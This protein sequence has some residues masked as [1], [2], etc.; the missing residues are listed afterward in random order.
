[1]LRVYHVLAVL[2]FVVFGINA[3]TAYDQ[4]LDSYALRAQFQYQMRQ[5]NVMD[6]PLEDFFARA[7][8]V[9]K[10][11]VHSFS[12]CSN[13]VDV[14]GELNPDLGNICNNQ[15]NDECVDRSVNKN[16]HHDYH[17]FFY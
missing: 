13:G 10:P 5:S 14:I 16:M 2:V 3:R 12:I 8:T 6:A 4:E 9:K 1:M 15:R 7:N 17:L 11:D